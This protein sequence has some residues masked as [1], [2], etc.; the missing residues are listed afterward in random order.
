MK[1]SE[2]ESLQSQIQN[3]SLEINTISEERNR[4]MTLEAKVDELH[5]EALRAKELESQL[6]VLNV[7]L[8]SHQS[9]SSPVPSDLSNETSASPASDAE[10][11]EMR[12]ELE[13]LRADY[14]RLLGA[15]MN[16]PHPNSIDVEVVR[17]RE[18]LETLRSNYEALLN[19]SEN[20][21]PDV[22]APLTVN[23]GKIDAFAQ[24][25][26]NLKQ[27]VEEREKYITLSSE[28]LNLYKN[29]LDTKMKAA[30]TPRNNT[31]TKE[32]SGLI[33][34]LWGKKSSGEG[35]E[36]LDSSMEWNGREWVK[37]KGNDPF[38]KLPPLPSRPKPFQS[39]LSNE[40]LLNTNPSNLKMPIPTGPSS[41]LLQPLMPSLPTSA[42]PSLPGLLPMQPTAAT[43][44]ATKGLSSRYTPSSFFDDDDDVNTSA[45]TTETKS[46]L[47]PSPPEFPLMPAMPN[48][49]SD[50]KSLVPLDT[51]SEE[52]SADKVVTRS[53]HP[54]PKSLT[55]PRT[56]TAVT[57]VSV[58]SNNDLNV[59]VTVSR[60]FLFSIVVLLIAV[61]L[62]NVFSPD[63][64]DNTYNTLSQLPSLF[65]NLQYDNLNNFQASVSDWYSKYPKSEL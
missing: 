14:D 7:Q 58:S 15:S 6:E 31:A 23:D 41:T 54:T 18:E 40:L 8:C 38:S 5:R 28:R 27:A 33:K 65:E 11:E 3:L 46:D 2:V 44:S 47:A 49:R 61:T 30:E 62:A 52:K 19:T 43:A 21:K 45:T 1:Q 22:I 9:I 24:E 59:T 12:K 60:F 42:S 50:A 48:V 56:S 20:T 32:S 53:S 63:L 4:L 64:V 26:A 25:I 37:K 51:T 17:L 10:K 16:F 35:E 34:K 36:H 57:D 39:S 13:S 55:T 29:E